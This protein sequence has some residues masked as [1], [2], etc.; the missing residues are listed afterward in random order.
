MEFNKIWQDARSQR[1][2][3]SL[4]FSSRSEEQDGHPT[5]HLPRHFDFSSVTAEQDSTKLDRKQDLNVVY[6]FCVIRADKKGR[7]GLWLAETFSTSPLWPLNRIQRN[8]TGSKI[9]T[10]SAK[11]V[12]FDET[13]LETRYQR[14]LQSLC[15]SGRSE[16]QNGRPGLWL[17]ETFSTS[18][19]N[20]IQQNLTGN[21]I[22]VYVNAIFQVCD[23][24]ADRKKLLYVALGPLIYVLSRNENKGVGFDRANDIVTCYH[25]LSYSL[26]WSA[27][28]RG[29]SRRPTVNLMETSLR[30]LRSL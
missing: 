13:W 1:L 16:K 27:V 14:P 11:F 23:F 12:L 28:D 24:R 9:S 3:I 2:L 18:L 30:P 25:N 5:S 6:Q 19:L 17:A 20:R 29:T 21:K 4:C 15:F 8:L 22:H 10:S 7:P 26:N